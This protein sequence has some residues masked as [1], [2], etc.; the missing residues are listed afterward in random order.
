MIAGAL[1]MKVLRF[2][3]P[4]PVPFDLLRFQI[5]E[6]AGVAINYDSSA[7]GEAREQTVTVALDNV[8]LGEIV[9]EAARQ[10]GLKPIIDTDGVRLV[11][12]ALPTNESAPI[13][14][15]VIVG[16]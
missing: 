8:T 3:Q 9:A 1:A 4:T 10:V 2:E 5:E 11:L 16:P 6:M 7:G 15:D 13:G 12:E 14:D